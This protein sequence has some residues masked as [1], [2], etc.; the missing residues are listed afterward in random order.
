MAN[1]NRK[2]GFG[3][4]RRGGSRKGVFRRRSGRSLVHRAKNKALHKAIKRTVLKTSET[5]HKSYM[6]TN[7]AQYYHDLLH[8]TT[9]WDTTNHTLFPGQGSSDSEREGDEI[10]T[11]G[12]KIRA[13][14]KIPTDRKNTAVKFWY[15]PGNTVQ[16][17]PATTDFQHQVTGNAWIDPV[18][19]KRWPGMRYLGKVRPGYGMTNLD[20]PVHGQQKELTGFFSA[21]IPLKK[22][23]KFLHDTSSTPSNLKEAGYIVALAYDTTS[24][25]VT[26]ILV[27]DVE[28]C[29]TLYYKDP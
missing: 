14:L 2:R 27:N 8:K 7:N 20:G 12:I 17:D 19:H 26:N 23:L 16:G 11:Q 6:M 5:K 1:G 21:W 18:Q 4:R 22:K 24:T 13:V 9:I 25:V 15:V 10:Y 3:K 28:M 29:A